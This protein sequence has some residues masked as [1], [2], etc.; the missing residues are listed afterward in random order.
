M[1]IDEDLFFKKDA[2]INIFKVF[3]MNYSYLEDQ[4]FILNF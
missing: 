3:D 1:E 2:F 4:N